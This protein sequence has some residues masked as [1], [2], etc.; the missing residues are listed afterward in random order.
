MSQ[1]E[2]DLYFSRGKLLND[3]VDSFFLLLLK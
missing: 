1:C 3:A 2:G